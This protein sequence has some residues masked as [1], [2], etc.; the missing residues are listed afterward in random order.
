MSE[1]PEQP[2]FGEQDWVI[3]GRRCCARDRKQN[4]SR[5][6]SV[7]GRQVKGILVVNPSSYGYDGRKHLAKGK[8]LIVPLSLRDIELDSGTTGIRPIV[9]EGLSHGVLLD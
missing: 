5:L 2:G 7:T 9:E 8:S 1:R 6:A 3:P 4:P